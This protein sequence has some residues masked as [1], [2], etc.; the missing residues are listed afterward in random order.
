MNITVSGMDIALF[1]LMCLSATL[2]ILMILATLSFTKI[3][4]RLGAFADKNG[5]D[6][7][8]TVMHFLDTA[9][10]LNSAS[11]RID[12]GLG[13]VG[14]TVGSLGSV[15]VGTVSAVGAGTS[16][17]I[18]VLTMIGNLLRAGLAIIAKNKRKKK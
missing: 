2:C 6:I 1:I 7:G 11:R 18:D 13:S 16:S 4:K 15:L 5:D 17:V 10:N 8:Q 9:K 12:Y 3:L 14:S